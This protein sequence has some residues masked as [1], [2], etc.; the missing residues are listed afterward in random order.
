MQLF[1][2][3]R[4]YVDAEEI[5]DMRLQVAFDIRDTNEQYTLALLSR[6]SPGTLFN[7]AIIAQRVSL[8]TM[9]AAT[10]SIT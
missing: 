3:L 7:E 5:E 10:I 4:F 9:T 8:T 6:I 2:N 1:N